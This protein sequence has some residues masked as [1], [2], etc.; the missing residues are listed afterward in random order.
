MECS[1]CFNAITSTTGK[2]ELSCSHPFHFSCLTTWFDKQKLQGA[3]ENCP[4]CRHE[5]NEFEKLPATLY[6][7]DEEDDDETWEYDD[8]EPTLDELAAQ[9]RARQRFMRYRFI[10]PIEEVKLY[11][12]NLIKACWRGYQDRL[13][14]QE[15]LCNKQDAEFAKDEI[16]KVKLEL[17]KL[18]SREKFL[19]ATIGLSRFQVK[20]FAATKIQALWRWHKVQ[21]AIG[22]VSGVWRKTGVSRWEKVVLNPEDHEP[23][24]VTH[25]PST[26]A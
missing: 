15:L 19:K 14:Y 26:L 20:N 6:T 24:T 5:S 1:I 13:L 25:L 18:R 17:I 10:N 11:S 7:N 21:A 4:L 9:E 22:T 12:A 16:Q 3:H 8:E 23:E 2:V